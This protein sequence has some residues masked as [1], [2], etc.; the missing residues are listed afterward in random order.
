MGKDGTDNC[1]DYQDII[2]LLRKGKMLD[3]PTVN[4]HVKRALT[5]GD[6]S[7]LMDFLK[8]YPNIYASA[9]QNIAIEETL[10]ALDPYAPYPT[11]KEVAEYLA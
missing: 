2:E 5:T 3:H 8:R 4:F 1:I 7:K 9:K 6:F 11:R 10:K